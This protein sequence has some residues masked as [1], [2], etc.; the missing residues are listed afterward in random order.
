MNQTIEA[1][2]DDEVFRPVISPVIK[3]NSMAHDGRCIFEGDVSR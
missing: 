3:A 1:I 2:F